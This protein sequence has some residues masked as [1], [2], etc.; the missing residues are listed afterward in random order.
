[1]NRDDRRGTEKSWKMSLH[2]DPD[3]GM[4]DGRCIP[5]TPT[6]NQLPHSFLIY[7]TK[8]SAYI[9]SSSSFSSLSLLLPVGEAPFSGRSE[10]SGEGE[11]RYSSFRGGSKEGVRGE[12]KHIIRPQKVSM[13]RAQNR[14]KPTTTVYDE[15]IG[16]YDS[17]PRRARTFR[18]PNSLHFYCQIGPNRESMVVPRAL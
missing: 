7:L 14:Q 8:S 1:M 5:A 16:K 13:G 6:Q 15:L 9:N 2:S 11:G 10:V 4:R 18:I 17:P 3:M 12:S